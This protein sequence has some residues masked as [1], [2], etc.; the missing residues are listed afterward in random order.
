MSARRTP[1]L[2]QRDLERLRG[3]HPRL[4]EAVLD[5]LEAMA[6][7]EFP[8]FV[9]QGVRTIAQQQALYAQG[10]TTPGTIV[11]HADGVT[12]RSQHQVKADGFGHAVDLAFVDDPDTPKSEVFDPGQ[13]W[14]LM[15]LMAEKRGL[16]W[17]GRWQ[18]LV[19]LPHVEL[20]ADD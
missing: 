3:V 15:G 7:L 9:T 13:P 18:G 19:D 5:I 20:H 4:M 6:V 17:G 12:K 16:V 10:R 14:D 1:A 2:I 11:T 8:M